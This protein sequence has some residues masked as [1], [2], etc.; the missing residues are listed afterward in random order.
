MLA[1]FQ[2]KWLLPPLLGAVIGYITNWIAIR[3]LFRPYREYRILGLKLPF[4]PGLLPARRG[5]IAVKVG[6][7]IA[8]ELINEKELKKSLQD[9][10]F[11]NYYKQ[12]WVSLAQTKKENTTL[13]R[14]LESV[15]GENLT[16]SLIQALRIRA[17]K[18]IEELPQA[19]EAKAWGQKFSNLLDGKK[20]NFSKIGSNQEIFDFIIKV[21]SQEETNQILKKIYSN[22]LQEFERD[23]T[24]LLDIMGQDNYLALSSLIEQNPEQ[25]SRILQSI[26]LFESLPKFILPIVQNLMQKH[27]SLSLLSNMMSEASL[28]E[29]IRNQL[30]NAAHELEQNRESVIAHLLELSDEVVKIPLTQLGFSENGFLSAERLNTLLEK[31]IR[32]IPSLLTSPDQTNLDLEAQGPSL[33]GLESHSGPEEIDFSAFWQSLF[34]SLAEQEEFLTERVLLLGRSLLNKEIPLAYLMVNLSD[35]W[36]DDIFSALKEGIAKVLPS[37][38]KTLDIAKTVERRLNEFPLAELEELTMDVVGRE[39]RAITQLG[40]LLGFIIGSLQWILN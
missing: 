26:L 20:F 15:L 34:L 30:S 18:L 8:Q 12:L 9:P 2:Y 1:N 36:Q 28:F 32:I 35:S 14:A 31:S 27:W 29:F 17:E 16:L 4:T 25:I 5:E 38:L 40:A 39:L 21:F 13:R 10:E 33:S 23:E 19:I 22:K 7:V 37:A 6:E 11:Y 3:M 24:T